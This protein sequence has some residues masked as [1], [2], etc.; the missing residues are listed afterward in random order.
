MRD[1]A[2]IGSDS[3]LSGPGTKIVGKHVMVERE[4]IIITEDHKYLEEGHDVM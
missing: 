2:S 4:C 3:Y 1:H